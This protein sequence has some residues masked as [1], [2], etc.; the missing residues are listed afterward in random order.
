MTPDICFR[1]VWYFLTSHVETTISEGARLLLDAAGGGK[2][3][4][5]TAWFASIKTKKDARVDLGLDPTSLNGLSIPDWNFKKQLEAQEQEGS[6]ASA[7]ASGGGGGAENPHVMEYAFPRKLTMA[8]YFSRGRIPRRIA[9]DFWK[10]YADRPRIAHEHASIHCKRRRVRLR[11]LGEDPVLVLDT[12]WRYD[13]YTVPQFIAFTRV[14]MG[15]TTQT[16]YDVPTGEG[17]ALLLVVS[18]ILYLLIWNR[19]AWVIGPTNVAV[20]QLWADVQLWAKPLGLGHTVCAASVPNGQ[21]SINTKSDIVAGTWKILSDMG[22]MELEDREAYEAYLGTVGIICHDEIAKLKQGKE[23][24]VSDRDRLKRMMR[25]K[26]TRACCTATWRVETARENGRDGIGFLRDMIS[27][28]RTNLHVC[29]LFVVCDPVV[30]VERVF[31][32][33]REGC[34]LVIIDRM[35][36]SRV[37]QKIREMETCFELND[38]TK[39]MRVIEDVLKDFSK[40]GKPRVL[41]VEEGLMIGLDLPQI[42]TVLSFTR[43]ETSDDYLQQLGRA[44]RRQGE[45]GAIFIHCVDHNNS[46]AITS[47]ATLVRGMSKAAV[48]L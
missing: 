12:L 8:D 16:G 24:E 35:T 46:D 34:I 42:L 21:G 9:S 29:P 33:R 14:L 32:L 28:R 19:V 15:Q 47:Q 43:L 37:V 6:S 3:L 44:A 48:R 25:P 40:E 10:S 36:D 4:E 41:I 45:H 39:Q 7:Q 31:R 26:Q 1:L 13:D 17:K 20:E 18:A 22:R 38:T 30:M 27:S 11:L 23:G 2:G 5:E